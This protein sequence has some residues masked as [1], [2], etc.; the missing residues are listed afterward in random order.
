MKQLAQVFGFS[1]LLTGTFL[2]FFTPIVPTDDDSKKIK[3]L[4][5]E[6]STL[7]NELADE[8]KKRQQ[9]K[10]QLDALQ[11]ETTPQTEPKEKPKA[12]VKTIIAIEE[13]SDSTS[14]AQSLEDAHIIEEAKAF[15]DFLVEKKYAQRI[16][17]G[18]YVVNENMSFKEIA[19]TIT[20][21]ATKNK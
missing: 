6:I 14:V 13:G 15:N 16:R 4:Q 3:A 10:Q 9:L 2:Y 8:N 5:K 1:F 17:I 7:Q 11:K 19:E 18:E 20:T 21:P 12:T